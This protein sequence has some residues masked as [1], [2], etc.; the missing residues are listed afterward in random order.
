VVLGLAPADS[1]VPC[2]LFDRLSRGVKATI[3]YRFGGN[4]VLHRAGWQRPPLT[5]RLRRRAAADR[6]G[7]ERPLKR[8][9][10]KQ[11]V[12]ALGA[13]EVSFDHDS[14]LRGGRTPARLSC[15]SYSR[16]IAYVLANWKMYPGPIEATALFARVQDGLREQ[17]RSLLAL[18]IVIVCP[19]AIALMAIRGVADRR[20]VRLGAQNCHW[21]LRGPYT[22]EISPVMLTGLVDYVLIG[23]SERR[24]AG[25]TDEQ[26]AAKVAAVAANAMT[27]ILFVGEEEPTA[28]A[29]AETQERLERGLADVDLARRPVVVVYEP[30][31][32]I[33]VDVPAAAD[34]VRTVV[35]RLKERL[36]QKG[37]QRPAVIYGGSVTADNVGEFTAIDA[38][39]GVGATRASLD[40]RQF[41]T[42]VE[43]V[44]YADMQR[45]G[46]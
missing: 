46:G 26:I 25:E 3:R 30:T 23:H 16:L 41:V 36:R 28:T 9:A 13:W 37:A 32:A 8:L 39:D 7:L 31:W 12:R 1:G 14:E 2:R 15:G 43:H 11:P 44:A 35:A 21:K 40:A 24:R 20:L 22:G 38:L 5:R 42:I 17:A 34:H 6:R 4:A 19:P 10:L 33:G 18:P 27:P 29:A 45:H